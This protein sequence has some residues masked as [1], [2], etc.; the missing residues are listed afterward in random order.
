MYCQSFSKQEHLFVFFCKNCRCLPYY[1]FWE[2][3]NSYFQEAI[4]ETIIWAVVKSLKPACE[5]ASFHKSC[6]PAVA[7]LY[8]IKSPVE[9]AENSY[10]SNCW[11]Q[12]TNKFNQSKFYGSCSTKGTEQF[13]F[14][15]CLSILWLQGNIRKCSPPSRNGSTT[16]VL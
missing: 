13:N 4:L 16:T 9:T 14:L 5:T 8:L 15:K 6:R 3:R 11:T 12:L 10:G 1:I 2:F 7:T